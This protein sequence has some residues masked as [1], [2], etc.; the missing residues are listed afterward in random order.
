MTHDQIATICGP[1]FDR[2]RTFYAAAEFI[3]RNPGTMVETGCYRGAGDDGNSTLIFALLARELDVMLHSFDVNGDSVASAMAELGDAFDTHAIIHQMDSITGIS[4]LEDAIRFAYLDSLDLGDDL[5]PC[6]RHQ[7]AEVGAVL[8][9][10][11]FPAAILLDDCAPD[12][13]GKTLLSA[14]FLK[15]RGWTLTADGYQL[16]FTHE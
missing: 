12:T 8:G 11:M 3:T 6:Q 16:L 2:A 7:L 13:G 10:M 14:A 1:V 5:G 9:K 15:D 4:H